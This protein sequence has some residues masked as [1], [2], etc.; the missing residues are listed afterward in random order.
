M[1]KGQ[2]RFLTGVLAVVLAVVMVI[3]YMPLTSY[4]KGNSDIQQNEETQKATAVKSASI[5]LTGS[6]L[7]NLE[8][9]VGETATH[10]SYPRLGFN[11]L[12]DGTIIA[13]ATM[14][15][16]GDCYGGADDGSVV[17]AIS[18]GYSGSKDEYIH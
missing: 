5:R 9:N 7:G 8:M 3:T 2:K 4:A 15:E 6:S 18:Q 16:Y 14:S 11:C 13:V 17:K 10:L 12:Y 1:N